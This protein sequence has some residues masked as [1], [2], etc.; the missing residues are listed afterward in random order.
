LLYDGVDLGLFEVK[1]YKQPDDLYFIERVVFAS[2]LLSARISG[3]WRLQGGEQLS[4]VDLEIKEGEMDR[5]MDLFG[6]Q[7][8]IA[9]G[10]LSGSM[11]IAWPGPPWA[12]SPPVTEGKVKLRIADGQLLEVD[13]GAAG[14]ILGLLSLNTLPRRLS[15]DFSDL[16]EKGFSFDEISG[17]FVIND[18]NAYTNDLFVEGPAAKIEIS[19]RIGLVDQDYDE[20]VT[21]IP[22][23]KTGIPL[24]GTLA[25]GPAV[26]AMLLVAETL[27]QDRLG[28]LN[29][30]AQKQYS[31]TGPWADPVIEKLQSTTLE[32]EPES[33]FELD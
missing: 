25:G 19:G 13:P 12:F 32:P 3:N 14:R 17:S 31:V 30:I 8:N 10:D 26:G 20:L 15:L 27:L 18:G 29:R 23:V 4:S 28:P 2:D 24:A 1:A 5:L 9:G 21:V 7:K 6:Y 33:S 16:F 22:Y 11:R